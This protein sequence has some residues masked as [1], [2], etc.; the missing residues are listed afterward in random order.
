MGPNASDLG[1]LVVIA[2]VTHSFT[3]SHNSFSPTLSNTYKT[4]LK[5]LGSGRIQVDK[6]W[7][8]CGSAASLFGGLQATTDERQYYKRTN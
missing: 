6:L 7:G 8:L 3:I 1:Q 2:E 5:F 4:L